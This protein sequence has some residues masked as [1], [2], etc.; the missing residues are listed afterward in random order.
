MTMKF[1][2]FPVILGWELTLACNLRCRHCASS[3]GSPRENELTLEESLAICDQLPALL[4]L[5][6]VFTGGEPLL[7]PH[8]EKIV[9]RLRDLNISV[10]MVTNGTQL[11]D[12]MIQRLL[13][14]GVEGLA[15]SLDGEPGTHDRLRGVEGL[16][17]KVQ[18]GISRLLEADLRVTVI[19]TVHRDSLPELPSMR[20]RLQDMGVRRW[21]LQPAF[22]F[23]RM[24]TRQALLLSDA[25]YLQL[26]RFI[27]EAQADQTEG[28]VEIFPADG[29]GYFS[30]LDGEGPQWLGCSAGIT[31]CGITS[32]GKV[33]GCLSW[34]D[35]FAFGDLRTTDLWDIWFSPDAFPQTRQFSLNEMG[36]ACRD[37]KH[38]EVCKGGC[39]AMSYSETGQFHSDPYCF[40][41]ILKKGEAAVA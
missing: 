16:H 8:W 14:A 29:V 4:V 26:G 18:A 37:C 19:T 41:A 12:D 28:A 7:S 30:E 39:S 3:A 36:G 22:G 6:V 1:E 32:D 35:Q 38:G 25:D 23:G 17:Q 2:S 31:T 15:V 20:I 27:Q 13:D 10:G 21:Q 11:G 33:K 5:E 34:P 9:R 40:R 24:Q